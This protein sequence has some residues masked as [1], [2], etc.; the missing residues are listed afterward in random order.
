M[1][2]ITAAL[3]KELRDRTD[4]SMSKCKEALVESN[5]DVEAA[6]VYLRKKGAVSA[7]K[8]ADREAKEGRIVFAETAHAAAIVEINCETDFFAADSRFATFQQSVV[9]QAA[10]GADATVE[11]VMKHKSKADPAHTLEEVRTHLVASCGENTVVKRIEVIKKHANQSLGF[12]S[13]AN[14]KILCMVEIEGASG[15]ETLAKD[16]G[17]HI[18]AEAPEY[19][20]HTSIPQD[21]I[22]VEKGI[23]AEQVKGKPQNMVDQIVNGKLKGFYAQVC[24]VEQK[25]VKDP[26]V[27]IEQLVANKGKEI[28]K[29]IK[30]KRF[31]RWSIG[32][33]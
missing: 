24:L 16:I 31:L 8:K 20:D 12:Y 13:H 33:A 7:V 22:D 11:G 15:L 14:G 19:L 2:E 30:I 6:I 17:M 28:G 29:A 27:S 21:R 5:G 18:A 1:A 9:E 23:A 25:F 4:I 26:S 10:T 3:V 32:A